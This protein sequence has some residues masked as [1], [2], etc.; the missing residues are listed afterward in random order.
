M[1]RLGSARR[2]TLLPP[3]TNYVALDA[4]A[5]SLVIARVFSALEPWFE[6]SSNDRH[7][8]VVI[9][10]VVLQS[11]RFKEAINLSATTSQ[12]GLQ[13]SAEGTL[14]AKTVAKGKRFE[15]MQRDFGNLVKLASEG[16]EQLDESSEILYHVSGKFRELSNETGPL[17][18]QGMRFPSRKPHRVQPSQGLCK[19]ARAVGEANTF[20]NIA[21]VDFPRPLSVSTVESGFLNH[22]TSDYKVGRGIETVRLDEAVR[23]LNI[24]ADD[25]E[26]I[27][28]RM[29]SFVESWR[30]MRDKLVTMQELIRP[31]N[32]AVGL[33]LENEMGGDWAY[34]V[35]QYRVYRRKVN[36]MN[37][38]YKIDSQVDHSGFNFKVILKNLELHAKNM[39]KAIEQMKNIVHLMHSTG[40][41]RQEFQ[42]SLSSTRENIDGH[43]VLL[44]RILE[45]FRTS[46]RAFGGI[47]DTEPATRQELVKLLDQ[48][49][50][51]LPLVMRNVYKMEEILDEQV[52]QK[53]L[54]RA[55]LFYMFSSSSAE[56]GVYSLEDAIR[57]LSEFGDA[58]L[59]VARFCEILVL[60]GVVFAETSHSG[61][62]SRENLQ[63]LESALERAIGALSGVGVTL[64]S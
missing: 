49:K 29:D 5:L 42:Q 6:A 46:V 39:R 45:K 15:E 27:L 64:S 43:F 14:F 51:C 48:A 60:V 34:M 56:L 31:N 32:A 2:S 61:E 36:A 50:T 24:V 28:E 55:Q 41:G 8:N 1:V 18:A 37:E 9:G 47:S 17:V 53:R 57:I 4:H 38:Y 11:Q 12:H 19:F 13:L 30:N 10:A 33:S 35:E 54:L 22:Y 52:S 25:I 63:Q 26:E 3:Q 59:G 44:I 7:A 21:L 20:S 16:F 62:Q 58:T 23:K 40:D